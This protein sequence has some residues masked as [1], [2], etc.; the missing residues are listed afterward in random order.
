MGL[1]HLDQ[2]AQTSGAKGIDLELRPGLVRAL[3]RDPARSEGR[4]NV[5]LTSVWV[6]R[7]VYDTSLTRRK[8]I[9]TRDVAL[10]VLAS[11]PTRLVM[12]RRDLLDERLSSLIRTIRDQAGGAVRVTLALRSDEL[13]GSRDHLNR[14]S[15]LRRM[16]EEWE[17]EIALDLTG[18]IDPRW[19]AEAAI[20][21]LM[22][23]LTMIRVGSLASRP[24]NNGR[25]RLTNRAI[26]FALDQ[27]YQD[28]ISI[29]PYVPLWRAFWTTAVAEAFIADAQAIRAK[30][31]LI[32]H[33][34]LPPTPSPP[35]PQAKHRMR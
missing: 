35:I 20:S 25:A 17:Y 5:P 33:I 4:F 29:A 11:R 27:G 21:R 31:E 23:R 6:S 2:V 9:T 26:A 8:P 34:S 13:E 3:L 22:P 30:Y 32:H 28:Y 7:N 10:A 16:A 15:A 24:P 1:P 12:D 14:L 18:P 19:E